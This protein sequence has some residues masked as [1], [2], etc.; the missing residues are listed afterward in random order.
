M[1]DQRL[2]DLQRKVNI[3]KVDYTILTRIHY[4]VKRQ[5]I[6]ECN[7]NLYK[8]NKENANLNLLNLK[9]M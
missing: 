6:Y 5:P 8:R 9:K 2:I 4:K 1:H 3:K 7:F